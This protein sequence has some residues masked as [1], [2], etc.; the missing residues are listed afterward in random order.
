MSNWKIEEIADKVINSFPDFC[1]ICLTITTRSWKE[2]PTDENSI[3]TIPFTLAK[4]QLE[5]FDYLKTPNICDKVILKT[6]QRGYTTVMMAYILWKMLYSNN[7]NIVYTSCD[8]EAAGNASRMIRR[9]LNE[10]PKI[11]IPDGIHTKEQP[12]S[13]FNK[14]RNNYL[15]M[16]TANTETTRGA[17]LTM[18]VM[19]EV[20][21]YEKNIQEEMIASL[22]SS[23]PNNRIWISTPRKEN[24]LYHNKVKEAEANGTLFRH[25][26]WYNWEEWF[27]SKDV[28]D[29]WRKEQTSGL[30]KQKI[31][32]ELDCGF[33]GAAEDT[34]W[35]VEPSAYKKYYGNKKNRA[36]VSLD[37]GFSDS[38]AILWARDY[39]SYI[40]V[41]DELILEQKTIPQVV[42]KIKEIGYP[43]KYGICDSSGKKKD[44]TSGNS[45]W[46]Q[47]QNMLGCKFRTRKYPDKIEML[48]VAN[49]EILLNKV[50][51]DPDKCPFLVE[52]FNNYEWK[53][54]KIPHDKYSHIH[55]SFCYLIYNWLKT[56]HS[57][58]Y[59]KIHDRSELGIYR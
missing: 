23:C 52:C 35:Y 29:A 27:G 5:F 41:F 45:S 9:M 38:T 10:V 26:Y 51:I 50:F 33:K 19:D 47:L 18:A 14:K 21:A 49:R 4:H 40:H 58:S 24:D 57:G 13:I 53:N 44:Q 3:I 48:R 37:L 43:L 17:T 42:N 15:L 12:N 31:L 25:D 54:D 28:A 7:E 46:E 16:K 34:I 8:A 1:S 30:T 2:M 39:G 55:D 56:P 6:R 11:F 36:I 59:V 20:S 32:R 22:T